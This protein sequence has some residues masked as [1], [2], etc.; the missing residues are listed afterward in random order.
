MRWK[1]VQRKR[2]RRSARAKY[3]HPRRGPEQ[4]RR[5]ITTTVKPERSA[6]EVDLRAAL[7]MRV[8]ACAPFCM[9]SAG[10]PRC[11]GMERSAR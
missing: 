2:Q 5:E 3:R 10:L 7:G 8:P 11:T 1:T 4:G 9:Q 6:P